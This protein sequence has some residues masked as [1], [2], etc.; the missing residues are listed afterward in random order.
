MKKDFKSIGTAMKAFLKKNF[1]YVIMAVSVVS[2][3]AL[4][5]VAALQNRPTP[6]TPPPN[7][8]GEEQPGNGTGGDE[9]GEPT[10]TPVSFIFPVETVQFG[11]M[12]FSWTE[13]QY[14]KSL[15][16]W[17]V[18]L[19]VDFTGDAN[20]PVMAVYDGVVTSIKTDSIMGTT[21]TIRHDEELV[22][23]YSSLATNLNVAIN[24][25]VTQGQVIG[26]MSN[27]G[28]H[29]SSEGHLLHFEAL[30]NG[31]NVD[32]FDYFDIEDK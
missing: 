10:F 30:V 8:G 12:V 25:Q 19:S 4:V 31:V 23:V 5:T 2:I 7:N 32:P 11:S 29:K 27:T 15:K 13:L 20:T 6:P 9:P 24:Q 22:T 21:V 3:A 1:Y 14:N 18:N 28:S 26:M 17:E 16:Q